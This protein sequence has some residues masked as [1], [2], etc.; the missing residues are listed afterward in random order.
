MKIRIVDVFDIFQAAVDGSI[1]HRAGQR[2]GHAV[3]DSV[4]SA[5]PSGVDEIDVA[6]VFFDAF[7]EKLRV[8]PAGSGRNGAAKQ[9]LKVV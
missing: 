9:V 2:K 8:A 1:D 5:C 4:L 6:V 3:A 7:A